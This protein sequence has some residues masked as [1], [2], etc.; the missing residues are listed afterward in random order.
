MQE[1]NKNSQTK[2]E[3]KKNKFID[4]DDYNNGLS[5]DLL[6][7]SLSIYQPKKKA[8]CATIYNERVTFNRIIYIKRYGTLKD[9]HLRYSNTR[10]LFEKGSNIKT[11][12]PDGTEK[13]T[14]EPPKKV[15]TDE[16]FF[17]KIFPG[18]DEK[19][20]EKKL[21]DPADYPYVLKLVNIAENSWQKKE[22]CFYCGSDECKNCL[23]PFTSTSKVIDYL[24][25]INDK[26]L[27]KND[28]LYSD[29][30]YYTTNKKEFELEL[31]FNEEKEKC[32]FDLNDFEDISEHPSHSSNS[33]DKSNGVSIY[34]CLEAFSKWET[35]DENNLWYCSH[36]KD[37]VAARKKMELFKVP[38]ILILHLERVQVQRKQQICKLRK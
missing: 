2:N 5:D 20:W 24:N 37:S 4:H 15:L 34:S 3:K 21:C 6:K 12:M 23:L 10:P 36:C 14:D 19:N 28:F 26:G 30:G 31:I 35:L 7:I 1:E 38:P 16:E 13:M 27:I 25:K 22:K 8:Y 17:A 9:L 11:N 29:H 18:V 33:L 32:L